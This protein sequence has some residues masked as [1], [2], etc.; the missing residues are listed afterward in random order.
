MGI[1][2]QGISQDRSLIV[3]GDS[4][5]KAVA[6]QRFALTGTITQSE[7]NKPLPGA[8]LFVD[9]MKYGDNSDANG[10]YAIFLPAGKYRVTARHI[11]KAPTQ[12][13][14]AIYAIGSRI[15]II[16]KPNC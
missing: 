12:K 4:T 1:P 14:I 2:Y 13:W 16:S 5:K 3:F 11:G 10:R 9:G 8:G 6:N 15:F 7:D